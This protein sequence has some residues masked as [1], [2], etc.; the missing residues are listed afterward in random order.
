MTKK[1]GLQ[2]QVA[3]VT[4]ASSGIGK[5]TALALAREGA[6][7]A[8]A[9][10]NTEALCLV[11]NEIEKLG[12]QSL[13]VP[14][15][16]THQAQV[17]KLVDATLGRWGRVDILVAN[18]GVYVRRPV[19]ALTV[20]DVERAMAVNFYGALYCV[21][22]VLPH[23]LS[24]RDGHVILVNT[25]DGKKAIPPDAPYAASKFALAG[26]GEV[27]RQEL[28]DS[29]VRVT[30]IFPGRVDTPMIDHLRV[31]TISSKLSADTVAHEIVRSIY[32]YRPEV[33]I[34]RSA[35]GLILLNTVFP[36]L[37]DKIVRFFHF[38]GWET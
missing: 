8:L 37:T 9:A 10:R 1:Q 18:A 36:S 19:I 13:V 20:E 6:H 34:P 16:V 27:L 11:A 7:L 31:P 29:G 25:I 26:F 5:A 38:E 32:R 2:D 4:G 33:V 21:L 22:A 35:W 24:Q 3:I 23:M 15:D 30:S 14:T 28:H 12:R 17:K